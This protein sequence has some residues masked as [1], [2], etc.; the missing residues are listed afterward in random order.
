MHTPYSKTNKSNNKENELILGL[1][2]LLEV[3]SSR[4]G[5]V[6]RKIIIFVAFRKFKLFGWIKYRLQFN[7]R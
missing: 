1:Q 7:E 3:I 5:K 2:K 6:L 4:G